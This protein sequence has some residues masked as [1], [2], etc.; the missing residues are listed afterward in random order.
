MPRVNKNAEEQATESL[1]ERIEPM[2]SNL[3]V[4]TSPIFICGVNR[5]IGLAHFE[6]IDVYAGVALPL[7]G[8]S[9]EQVRSLQEAV[10]AAATLGFNMCSKETYQRY[11]M[12]VQA[13]KA[14]KE[15]EGSQ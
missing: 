11:D 3:V 4:T 2:L 8:E 7:P 15:A 5:R 1:G 6:H 10:E 9:V 13:Q 14:L 12:M